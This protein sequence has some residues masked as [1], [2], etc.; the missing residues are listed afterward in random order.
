M[1]HTSR[2]LW[3]WVTRAGGG[4]GTAQKVVG[5]PRP[6]PSAS[7]RAAQVSVRFHLELPRKLAFEETALL[8]KTKCS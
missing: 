7:T 8:L 5:V 6:P 1:F 2:S 4:E 3:V